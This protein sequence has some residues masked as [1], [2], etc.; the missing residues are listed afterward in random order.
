MKHICVLQVVCLALLTSTSA[1]AEQ[2]GVEITPFGGYQ[3]GG[4]FDDIETGADLELDETS[5]YG[6]MVDVD[7]DWER[8]VEVYF[9]RQETELQ[10]ESGEFPSSRLFDV[11]V[12]YYHVGG[13]YMW[14]YDAFRPFVVGT[15]GLTHFHPDLSGGN[16]ETDF[17]MALGGGVKVMPTRYFG[18]RFEGRGFATF[19][20]SSTSIYCAD[21]CTVFFSSDVFTQFQVTAGVVFR[22]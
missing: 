12:S 19:V 8:Q 6:L 14:D 15:L 1:L 16:S 11:D 10:V 9:S 22:F 4:D 7:L 3:F 20:D 13:I 17:S 2:Y 5:A 18:F 21:G